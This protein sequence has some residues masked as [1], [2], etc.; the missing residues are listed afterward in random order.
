M[1]CVVCG[2]RIEEGRRK[3]LPPREAKYC[4]KCRAER[5]RARLKYTWRPEYDAYLKAHYYGGLKRRFRVLSHMVRM[6]GLPRWYIKRQAARLGLT[7]H[8]DRQPWTAAEIRLLE[9]IVG[10]VSTATIAERLQRPESSVV[11]KLKRM[12]TSRRVRESYT[13]REL[14]QC[15]G[16][17]HRKISR[18]IA[19]GWLQDHLQGTRR[20]GG[21][22]NDI[23]RI[24]EEDIL[25][26]IKK[27][28]QEL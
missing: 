26:F 1:T 18:W 16:E 14:E 2:H 20:H 12:K 17:D 5:R 13:M 3:S 7:M 15:L 22:G 27:H 4:L 8:M 24:R 6:T 21:N 19:N 10:M 11:N 28:P 9:G 23:H 25:S